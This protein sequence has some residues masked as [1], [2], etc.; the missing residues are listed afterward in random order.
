M[1]LDT[2]IFQIK[3]PGLCPGRL[4]SPDPG[5]SYVVDEDYTANAADRHF[6]LPAGR[7]GRLLRKRSDFLQLYHNQCLLKQQRLIYWR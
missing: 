7:E 5:W 1:A 2:H 6:I 3:N 4:P